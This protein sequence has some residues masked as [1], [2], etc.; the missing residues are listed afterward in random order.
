MALNEHVRDQ[1][2]AVADL[3]V[4]PDH[5]ARPDFDVAAQLSGLVD[6][7]GGVNLCAHSGRSAFMAANSHSV[8]NSPLTSTRPRN[9][10]M[11]RRWKSTSTGISIVSPG[12]TGR[13]KRA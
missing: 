1:L 3:H 10:K 12:I 5:A 13:L 8:A 9:L 11:L 2:A 7:R 6:N 4:R